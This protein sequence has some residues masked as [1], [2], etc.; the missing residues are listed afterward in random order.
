MRFKEILFLVF[1]LA[2]SLSAGD[3]W[4]DLFN[5]KDLNNFEILN[6][7]GEFDIDGDVIVGTCKMDVPNT[8]LATK[9]TYKD[10]ILEY[11]IKIDDGINSGMQI[12]SLSTP[13]YQ[14]GRV[15]GYQIEVDPSARAWTGGFYEE[16]RRG[17]LYNLECNPKGKT[18]FK[19]EAWNHFRVEAIGNHFRV[20]LNG[21]PTADVIDDMIS[22]GFIAMQLHSIYSEKEIGKA[23]QKKKKRR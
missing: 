16:G 9:K 14:D 1:L 2:V 5:G 22:E 13:E 23:V 7:D 11:E 3:S 19:N 21:V 15:H 8:F 17:W 6:G 18:A 10:F 20:W 4:Q 12:R